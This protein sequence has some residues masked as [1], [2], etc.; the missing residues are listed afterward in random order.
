VFTGIVQCLGRVRAREPRGGDLRLELE[1]PPSFLADTGVGD[2]I[3]VNGVC[4]T[5]VTV[6]PAAFAADISSETLARTTL[7][8]LEAGADVNLESS[9]RA[10]QPLSGHFVSGHVDATAKILTLREDAR[11][12]VLEIELPATL[13][14]FVVEKGSIA[15]DG[16]SLTVNTAAPGRF[17][18]TI[19]PHTRAV[20]IIGGYRAGTRVNLEA[21][22][23]ARYLRGL[24]PQGRDA[25]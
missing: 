15:V 16:V 19:I 3:A 5:A 23:I 24:L 4:L 7:G 22:L 17:G 8:A 10:G 21:D 20:T 18:V 14:P 9:L 25:V 13:A 11:A 1:T 6:T 2:S 12:L